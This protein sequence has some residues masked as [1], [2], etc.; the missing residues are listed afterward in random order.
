MTTIPPLK[1]IQARMDPAAVRR[2]TRMYNAGVRDVLAELLQN[3]RRSGAGSVRVTIRPADDPERSVVAIEDD[4]C[5]VRDPQDLL[6]FGANGWRSG[7]TRRE[8]AAGMGFAAL[9]RYHASLS[10]R[11]GDGLPWRIDLAPEDF[12]GD[13]QVAVYHDPQAPRH[14]TRVTF[15]APCS[16][17]DAAEHARRALRYYPLPTTLDAGADPETAE[18]QE[19]LDDA[20]YV[21]DWQG[22]QL[23]ASP[24][25]VA[26]PS[27][28]HNLNFHGHT[29]HLDLP[30]VTTLDRVTWTAAVDVRDCPDLELV[31]PARKEAVETPFLARLR[32]QALRT[33]Y[34]AMQQSGNC[35][36]AFADWRRARAAGIE[37]P[38]PARQ[39]EPWRPGNANDDVYD[40]PGRKPHFEP[41]R[42]NAVIVAADLDAPGQHT[43][44]RAVAHGKWPRRLYCPEPGLEGFG[45][46]DRLTRLTGWTAFVTLDGA[47]TPVGDGLDRP[48]APE[49]APRPQ[50]AR[51]ELSLHGAASGDPGTVSLA[52]DVVLPDSDD[53]EPPV[54]FVTQ[55]SALTPADL[56]DLLFNAYFW[57]SDDADNDSYDTQERRFRD[58]A[59]YLA[60]KL[61]SGADEAAR[62]ALYDAL[63]A[64]FTS[65][66]IPDGKRLVAVLRRRPG[67]Y[68]TVGVDVRVEDDP[69]SEEKPHAE[70]RP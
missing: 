19:F 38:E 62:S 30:Q 40:W 22:L 59:A 54:P 67:A 9:A 29:L 61:L 7:V 47:E 6:S 42:T 44:A 69:G 12:L 56:E 1:T 15:T 2:V 14:G 20:V 17:A 13:T 63:Q 39:L 18:R 52:T 31:L 64:A 24:H 60:T 16:L 58:H 10:T 55:D 48:A 26:P 25:A 43:L 70:T 23:G 35:Q 53:P 57:P 33:I 50:A 37:L 4:G 51:V 41:L 27:V 32:E 28:E 11:P 5:G 49:N 3:A 21:D 46:Y 65:P 36:A 66:M 45:W 68:Y 8:D 34:R